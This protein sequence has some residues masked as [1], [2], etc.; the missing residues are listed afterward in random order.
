MGAIRQRTSLQSRLL[1]SIHFANKQPL[2]SEEFCFA[3]RR[4]DVQVKQLDCQ[5]TA[6][7]LR[8]TKFLRFDQDQK[9]VLYLAQTSQGSFTLK[10]FCNRKSTCHW[11]ELDFLRQLRH[12]SIISIYGAFFQA[13]PYLVLESCYGMDFYF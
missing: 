3:K 2:T 5:F 8:V 12:P 11:K 6:E 13:F 10:E 1:E 9:T 4:C 7:K